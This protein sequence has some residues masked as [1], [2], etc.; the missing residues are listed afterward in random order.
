[1]KNLSPRAKR[2]VLALAQDEVRRNSSRQMLPEHIMLALVK[3]GDGIGFTVFSRFQLDVRNFQ[4]ELE[5]FLSAGDKIQGTHEIQFSRRYNSMMDIAGIESNSLHNDYVGTEHFLL[6]AIREEDSI[7]S[8]FFAAE[9]VTIADVRLS[10]ITLQAQ[11]LSSTKQSGSESLVDSVFK[12]LFEGPA[13]PGFFRMNDDSQSEKPQKQRQKTSFLAEFS[14]DLT[15][16]AAEKK[17]D[18][19]VG[20]DREIRRM[21]QILSRRTKNNPVLTG[22]PGVGKT[23]VVEGL[24]QHIVEGKVPGGLLKKRILALDLAGLV[25]GTKYRGEFEERMKRMMKELTENRDIILFIDE[26]HTIIGAGGPE[27]T[28]DAS[29]IMKPA[30][31]RGEI[32]MIGA[33]TTKEYTKYIEKDHA[34]ERRFQVVKIEE[35][36]DDE[37]AR[38]LDGIKPKFEE[39]H[40]VIYGDGTVQAAVKLSRRYI[41]ERVLPDKAI[42]ILDEAGAAKKIQDDDKPAELEELE[43]SINRLTEEKKSLVQNQDYEKAALIRDKVIELKKR[44]TVFSNLWKENSAKTRKIVTISDVEHIISEMTGIPAEQLSSSEAKRIVRMEEELHRIVIGQDEAVRLISGAI[45]RSRAGISSPDRPIG[46]FIFLGP[47]GVGKTQLAK[48]LAEYLFGRQDALIRIDMSDFMEK[49]NASRLVGAPPGYVGYEEGGILTE[50]VRRHPYSV[51]LLDEIE[52]AH[53]DIFNLLLQI[54]EEGELSDN[55]G[56]TVNF[57]NTVVIMTSNAGARQITNEGRA[58]FSVTEGVVPYTEMKSG[59]MNELKKI[60]GP[61]ILNR[62]DDVVVFN[63]LSRQEVASI[64]E[65]QLDELKK[66]LA[67]KD[68][69]FSVSAA[70]KEYL[71]QNGYNP[72]MGARPMRRLIRKEI[73]EPLA[74]QILSDENSGH[75]QAHVEARGGKL[76][77]RLETETEKERNRISVENKT[78]TR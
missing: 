74:V 12:N 7:T 11:Q 47:T 20:R 49:H 77:L 43:R 41:P 57:R 36:D 25:A 69:S 34:L 58:G 46:S 22:E 64:L 10:V 40:N 37:T 51:V 39:Y 15:K 5:K 71:A 76:H 54:L 70:A 56:H 50:K 23:A 63:T 18:P 33:T 61:E 9:K 62:I 48:A 75:R 52:K 24:A 53:S 2:I 31:S 8:R 16:I 45:R 78:C 1:M 35:P 30:L 32:Q 27:G 67:E 55:L 42:D 4:L 60:M 17:S 29:N 72:S 65:I 21:I 14:R 6:A 66:R 13:A 59:A 26:F 44:L 73:E 3:S 68:I 38:I 19:V 28:M